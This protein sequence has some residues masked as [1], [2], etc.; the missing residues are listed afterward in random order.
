LTI[1]ELKAE[2]PVGKEVYS[3]GGDTAYTVES[4]DS[5]AVICVRTYRA[6][7]V[8]YEEID[9]R[10]A[11]PYRDEEHTERVR[12]PLSALFENRLIPYDQPDKIRMAQ[13]LAFGRAW[14]DPEVSVDS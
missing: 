9:G 6:S 8:R 7:G 13:R 4:W 5:A 14:D 11:G 2:F 12:Y 1:E 10:P 3:V